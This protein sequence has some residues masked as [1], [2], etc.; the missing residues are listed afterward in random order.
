MGLPRPW[1]NPPPGAPAFSRTV[2]P[3]QPLPRLF[4][5]FV[6]HA[7]L[8]AQQPSPGADAWAYEALGLYEQTPIGPGDANREQLR[9]EQGATWFAGRSLATS[10]VG[11][12]STGQFV[13]QPLIVPAE[14]L[15]EPIGGFDDENP[16]G[17]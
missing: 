3:L 14:L 10:G 17:G 9:V 2:A 6:G 12:L 8:Y 11:G 4:G 15:S 7:H 13:N 16:W 1:W 5:C